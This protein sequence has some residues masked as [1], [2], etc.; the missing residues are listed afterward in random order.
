MITYKNSFKLKE[1]NKMDPHQNNKC[2]SKKLINL[3]DIFCRNNES[4]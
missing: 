4:N 1:T 2:P 3:I